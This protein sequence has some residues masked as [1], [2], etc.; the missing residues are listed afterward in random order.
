MNH[1][2]FGVSRIQFEQQGCH[3]FRLGGAEN[4]DDVGLSE[5]LS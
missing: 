2:P 4:Y 5:H 1:D 3:A